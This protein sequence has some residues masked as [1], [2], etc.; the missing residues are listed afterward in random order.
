MAVKQD[1]PFLMGPHRDASGG[2]HRP[3]STS[4]SSIA[5]PPE[6]E[7]LLVEEDAKTSAENLVAGLLR[8]NLTPELQKALTIP[9]NREMFAYE[10]Q[11]MC[12]KV[13]RQG[14]KS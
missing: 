7:P 6:P 3:M 13:V 11:K 5:G 2:N 10:F 9:A 4:R 12:L 1:D 8:G 14:F